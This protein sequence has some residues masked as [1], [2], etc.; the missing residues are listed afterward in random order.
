M[1]MALSKLL[2]I[3]GVFAF[4][5]SCAN[6]AEPSRHS[7]PVKWLLSEGLCEPETVIHDSVKDRL[8]V[9][10]ICGFKKDGKGYLSV[11]NMDG[12]PETLRWIEGLDAPAGMAIQGRKLYVTDLDKVQV[13]DL[14]RGDI[15]DVLGPYVDAKAFNDIAVD[16]DETV[17][18]SDSARHKIIK[19]SG[20]APTSF[21]DDAATFKFANG[22]HLD[23]AR[24]YVGGENFWVIDLAANKIDEM[25][26][27]GLADIDGI[28]TDGRGGL[29]VS[30]VGG[31][32]W[33]LPLDKAPAVWTAPGVSST[34]HAYLPKGDLVIVPTGYD[35]TVIAFQAPEAS[36]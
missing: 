34:N 6:M 21:P 8:I 9:S 36:P 18:V 29:T 28:E 22:L 15:T 20:G 13:I 3:F 31:D 5:V 19:I 16:L 25:G 10:N 30:I 2:L 14:D 4:S 17:Y 26:I 7:Q 23:G 32:V 12:T 24:L 1:P 27:N 11:L 33:H 35:N